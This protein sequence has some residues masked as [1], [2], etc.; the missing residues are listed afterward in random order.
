MEM[1]DTASRRG[2]LILDSQVWSQVRSELYTTHPILV[3]NLLFVW[4]LVSG[5][6]SE[7]IL[8][9]VDIRAYTHE[10]LG[11]YRYLFNDQKK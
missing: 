8:P 11:L 3:P 7:E 10:N 9:L 2:S 5:G 6:K 4:L 1:G